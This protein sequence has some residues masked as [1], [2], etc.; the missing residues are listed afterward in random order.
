MRIIE[1]IIQGLGRDILNAGLDRLV[2]AGYSPIGTVYDETVLRTLVYSISIFP[3]GS[4]VVLEN[5][6]VG[7]VVHTNKENPKYP[8][9]KMLVDQD[10]NIL[11]DQPVIET[12]DEDGFKILRILEKNEKTKLE[13]DGLLPSPL[14]E[15]S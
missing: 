7:I 12:H 15:T 8:L 2:D 6:S 3:L 1:N 14:T 5:G 10:R 11:R 9:V 13:E 4:H